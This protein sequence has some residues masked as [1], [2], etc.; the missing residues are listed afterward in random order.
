MYSYSAVKKDGKILQTVR[1]IGLVMEVAFKVAC[2]R[3][4]SAVG[5]SDLNKLKVSG[6]VQVKV[7]GTG[8]QDPPGPVHVE[9]KETE[10][11]FALFLYQQLCTLFLSIGLNV[12]SPDRRGGASWS[13][14]L[15][16]SFLNTATKVAK[17]LV[18]LELKVSMSH[19]WERRMQD[20]KD[21][22]EARFADLS[23]SFGAILCVG[24]K[25]CKVGREQWEATRVEAWIWNGNEWSLLKS[26]VPAMAEVMDTA[27]PATEVLEALPWHNCAS[28][29]P[30][31]RVTDFLREAG[32]PACNAPQRVQVWNRLL[33]RDERPMLQKIPLAHGKAPWCGT[34]AS[35]RK[36]YSYILQKRRSKNRGK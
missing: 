5:A 3:G 16:C 35:F 17:G 19:N 32:E 28:G 6:D 1:I 30:V 18:S 4:F 27:T 36:V 7:A 34:R 14:D 9:V 26:I 15:V 8:F 22:C 29:P 2:K 20:T 25:V 13:H 33:S 21:V 12:F 11:G 31:A 23:D 10:T 24:C